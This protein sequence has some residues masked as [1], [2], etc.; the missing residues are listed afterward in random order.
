MATRSTLQS[1]GFETVSY[2]ILGT[3]ARK[4]EIQLGKKQL[5]KIWLS[6]CLH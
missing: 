1:Q 4:S 5:A 2:R 6:F 3:Q